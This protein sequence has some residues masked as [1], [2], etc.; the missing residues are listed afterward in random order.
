MA[1]KA[2]FLIE[3]ENRKKKSVLIILKFKIAIPF[4][5]FTMHMSQIINVEISKKKH[6]FKFYFIFYLFVF[7]KVSFLK[8]DFNK[9]KPI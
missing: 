7:F 9:Y 5:C 2:C 8:F 3:L 6:T 1:Y 4:R